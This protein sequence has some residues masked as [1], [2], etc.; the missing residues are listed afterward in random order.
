LA[1]LLSHRLLVP[2]EGLAGLAAAGRESAGRESAVRESM[3]EFNP[4]DVWKKL[5]MLEVPEQCGDA[6]PGDKCHQLVTWSLEKGLTDYPE[7]FVT[8]KKSIYKERN[9]RAIQEILYNKGKAGCIK[10]CPTIAPL[11]KAQKAHAA[12]LLAKK[13]EA[14]EKAQAEAQAQAEAKTRKEAEEKAR[15]A[16]D[17]EARALEKAR[18]EAEDLAKAA[19]AQARRNAQTQAD[20]DKAEA[21]LAALDGMDSSE[22][23]HGGLEA[24]KVEKRH[25]LESLQA[26]L[27]VEKNQEVSKKEAAEQARN[28]AEELARRDAEAEAQAQKDADAAKEKSAEEVRKES[29]ESARND[30]EVENQARK[31]VDEKEWDKWA[32]KETPIQTDSLE[33][34]SPQ[35]LKEYLDHPGKLE[36][37]ASSLGK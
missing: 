9:R 24:L 33:D 2:C 32:A 29:E 8:Y 13:A 22:S 28:A 30:E 27:R 21:E 26:H 4:R 23:L 17:A 18:Q 10:P 14:E 7:W 5:T 3:E 25:H 1:G 36:K 37:Y 34:M 12:Q 35:E 16:K 6:Q 11:T 19:E 20:I 31:E 15:E